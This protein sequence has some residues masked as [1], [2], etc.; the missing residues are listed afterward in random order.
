MYDD[1]KDKPEPAT[2]DT[3]DPFDDMTLVPYDK[4]DLLGEPD[5][6]VTLDVMMDNLR[7]GKNYAFFNNITY[8]GAKVPTLYTALNAGE[9]ATNPTIYGSYTNSIVLKKNEI[10]QLVVNNLDSG[11]HPFHL[12][13]HAFQAVFR[14]EEE[15]G[16]WADTKVPD[17]NLPSTPMRRDTLVIYPNGNIVMR[18]KADNPG[19]ILSCYVKYQILTWNRRLA[20]PLP[21]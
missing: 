19:E 9:D 6:E 15:A 17:K 3:F 10:V 11:R 7:D 20:L 13:G 21:H 5:H 14:S 2:V 8:T 4:M 18:F 16:I 12:H 1:S